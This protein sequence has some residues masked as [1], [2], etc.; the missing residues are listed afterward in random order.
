MPIAPPIQ[1]ENGAS[2]TINNP[3]AKMPT[4]SGVMRVT[5]RF[6][7]RRPIMSAVIPAI[8]DISARCSKCNPGIPSCGRKNTFAVNASMNRNAQS[9]GSDL[10]FDRLR[11]FAVGGGGAAGPEVV[12][13]PP[14]VAPPK[15]EGGT[16]LVESEVRGEDAACPAESEAG[17]NG[18]ACLAEAG[19]NANRS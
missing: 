19:L 7:E 3:S 5:G 4:S 9:L 8:A 14:G 13:G 12:A 10:I 16:C 2:T 6:R 18:G 11:A 1:I 15:D 17:D